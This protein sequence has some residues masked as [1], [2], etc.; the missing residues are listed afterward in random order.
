MNDDYIRRRDAL[1]KFTIAQDGT[2]ISEVDIDNFLRQ[3]PI[4]TVKTILREI[5]AADVLPVV[6]CKDCK[7][8]EIESGVCSGAMAY[9]KVPDDWFCAMGERGNNEMED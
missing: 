7:Y 8:R 3:V 6:L 1:R 4:R 2:R 5:P 9:A